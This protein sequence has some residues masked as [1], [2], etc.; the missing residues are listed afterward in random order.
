M[1]QIFCFGD[2]IT[3]GADDVVLSGWVT[4]LRLYLEKDP[5]FKGLVCNLGIPGETT[6]GLVSRFETETKVRIREDK[7]IESIF[8]FAYGANDSAF[9]PSK[10]HFRVNV[11]TFKEN[12]NKTIIEAKKFSNKIYIQTITPVV[13]EETVNPI[14]KDKS[15][16]N[17]WIEEY[18]SKVLEVAKEQGIEVID[19]N[20]AY[21]KQNYKDLFCKDGLHPNDKG[22]ELIFKTVLE[23]IT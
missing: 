9:V 16:T 15:R 1:T 21:L 17:K 19:I 8:I 22:H 3:Y 10:N 18:N 4:R 20:P 2:S 23:K 6:K 11:D 12:L 13:E 7:E 5:N 14:N